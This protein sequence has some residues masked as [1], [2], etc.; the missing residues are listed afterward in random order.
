MPTRCSYPPLAGKRPHIVQ[1][2]GH[3][4][5]EHDRN[6]TKVLEKPTAVNLAKR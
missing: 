3:D 5:R 1:K 2:I 6:D 4:R